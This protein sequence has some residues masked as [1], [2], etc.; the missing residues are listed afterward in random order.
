M[1]LF[2]LVPALVLPLALASGCHEPQSDEASEFRHG[3]GPGHGGHGH[4]HGGGHDCDDDDDDD[5]AP[6]RIDAR[7]G[8][9]CD[10]GIAAGTPPEA[11]PP[12]IERDRM[13][14]S[15]QP[16][17]L[18]GKHL[19]LSID[20][21]TGT[22]YS[23]GRYLFG[24]PHQ[25]AAYKKWVTEDY[26]L[27]GVQFLE[28]PEVIDPSC[29]LWANLGA[30]ELGDISSDHVVMRTERW[31]I[32]HNFNM[33][34]WLLNRVDGI[35]DDAVDA[36][37]TGVWLLYDRPNR[38][39]EIVYIDD[40][41]GPPPPFDLDFP[42]LIALATMPTLGAE[43][44]AQGWTRVLDR[45]HFVFSIWFPFEPGDQGDAS[46]WPNSPPL[47]APFCGD[48]VCSVSRGE[49][50]DSCAAD[51]TPTCGDAECDP[52][53]STSSCPGDCRLRPFF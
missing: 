33:Q 28:R 27:D 25:A 31:Q 21:M 53:E 17:M 10:F 51:C 9:S 41:V 13:F 6:I 22:L 36:G 48:G 39:V 5:G 12:A 32:P 47:P 1:T 37:L 24:R 8:F 49:A 7:A 38:L 46:L 44:D 3:G 52:D 4:G 23:G 43:F 14:M 2:R 45:T 15:D 35:V 42:S 50:N 30:F 18:Y 40:R 11:I 19:P 16:G 26:I 20:P 29:H 34:G